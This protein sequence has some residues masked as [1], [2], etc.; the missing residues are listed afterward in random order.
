ML[1]TSADDRQGDTNRAC[2][3]AAPHPLRETM[4]PDHGRGVAN[5]KA[6]AGQGTAYFTCWTG[7]ALEG[8]R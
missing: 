4:L 2:F 3:P 5:A 7:V 6:W 8:V 1:V